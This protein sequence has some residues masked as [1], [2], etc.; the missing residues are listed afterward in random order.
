MS[1]T[2]S[3]DHNEALYK[4]AVS[5]FVAAGYEQASINTILKKAGMSKGQFYYHF[6]NKEDL[7][8]ALTDIMIERKKAFMTSVM[9]LEDWQQDIFSIFKT[10]LEHGLQFAQLYPEIN[11][12]S[13]SFLKEKGNPIYE[14]AMT[15]HNFENNDA[16]NNMIAAAYEKG[17]FREELP[18][19]FVQ[20]TIGYLF[21]H[22]QDFTDLTNAKDAQEQL[23]YLVD[24]MRKGL[25]REPKPPQE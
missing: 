3:F 9:K 19:S 12:F 24:F 21:T 2:K 5:E 10:Q 8:L 22:V 15:R 25:A 11:A 20:K 17:E 18:L 7:Y 13:D 1:F 16:I 4:T 23:N 6:K 14:T